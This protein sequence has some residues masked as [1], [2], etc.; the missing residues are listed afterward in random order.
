MSTKDAEVGI[1]T[2]EVT[3]HK[4]LFKFTSTERV[5]EPSPVD[6]TPYVIFSLD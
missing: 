2:D 1:T 5:C 4:S 6:P 3:F